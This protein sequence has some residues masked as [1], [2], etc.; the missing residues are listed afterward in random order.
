MRYFIFMFIINSLNCTAQVNI[1]NSK[2][3][4]YLSHKDFGI[5]MNFG[6]NNV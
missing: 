3:D 5:I 1:A 2:Q 6:N 4:E